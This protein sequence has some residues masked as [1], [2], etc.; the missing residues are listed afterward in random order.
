MNC[1]TCHTP[2]HRIDYE[3]IALETCSRCNGEWLDHDEVGKITKLREVRFDPQLR[4]AVAEAASIKG[5][6]AK[7]HERRVV[8]PKCYTA[9]NPINYGGGSGIII[10]KCPECAGFWLDDKELEGI[11][12][13]VEGWDD[14]LPE[15][16]SQH[17]QRLHDVSIASETLDE[18]DE[19][20]H[21]R[22]PVVGP[23]INACVNGVLNIF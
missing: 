14:A 8:C 2:M 11:Q 9:M 19:I 4:R 20:R 3:G 17:S 21:S 6:P 13:V 10:D 12:M 15:D 5:I 7:E 16:L 1:S 23:F 18:T 22:L